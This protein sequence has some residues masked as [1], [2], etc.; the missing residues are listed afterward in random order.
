MSALVW[1]KI[2]F[3]LSACN[4]HLIEP[5]QFKCRGR[6]ISW[7]LVISSLEGF[8][9]GIFIPLFAS[10]LTSPA[11]CAF[12]CIYEKGFVCHFIHLL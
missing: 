3:W 2:P 6:E 8:G 7:I 12:R 9:S 10:D 5:H 4:L 11:S 1:E